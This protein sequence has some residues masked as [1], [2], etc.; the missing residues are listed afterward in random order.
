MPISMGC[1]CGRKFKVKDEAGGKKVRCPDCQK[2]LVVPEPDE[3]P[4]DV[5]DDWE[6]ELPP[7]R[8]SRPKA[9]TKK[10][11]S[12]TSTSQT[13]ATIL[14]LVVGICSFLVAYYVSYNLFRGKKK[15]DI[16]QQVAVAPETPD[17][18]ALDPAQ[19]NPANA[20]VANPTTIDPTQYGGPVPEGMMISPTLVREMELIMKDMAAQLGTQ[21]PDE[22]L[23]P[24]VRAGISSMR[25]TDAQLF[26]LS[27]DAE[28]QLAEC[29]EQTKSECL[30]EY[31]SLYSQLE[32]AKLDLPEMVSSLHE[33]VKSGE[34]SCGRLKALSQI[35]AAKLRMKTKSP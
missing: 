27:P 1:Q 21:L 26:C 4:D 5:E 9:K 19:A 12:K 20:A 14:K 10:S 35:M 22:A 34:A 25:Q 18:P 7:R 28:K 11:G 8:A 31:N 2:V 15:D 24:G 13:G 23:Q 6:E 3:F 33:S 16:T 32:A 17:V 29:G 30:D